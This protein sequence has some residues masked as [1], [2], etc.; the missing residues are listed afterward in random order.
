ME[1]VEM[2]SCKRW[3]CRVGHSVTPQQKGWGEGRRD[4][5]CYII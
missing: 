4:M 3:W 5:V 1:V 2:M